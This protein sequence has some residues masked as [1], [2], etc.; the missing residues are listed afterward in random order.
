MGAETVKVVV[1]VGVDVAT[2]EYGIHCWI[3]GE[4]TFALSFLDVMLDCLCQ[5][6]V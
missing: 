3:V 2:S 1:A 6:D 5:M 4:K